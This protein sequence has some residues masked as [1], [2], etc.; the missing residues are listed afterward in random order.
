MSKIKEITAREIKDSRGN[1]TVEVELALSDSRR[2]VASCPSGA[3]VG[4]NE[5]AAIEVSKAIE[6]I[7]EVI[8]PKLR[9]KSLP[10]GR[11]A[12]NQK[13]I[14]EL[15]IALD[16]TENKSHLGVN[17]IL[18]I[19]IA[20][21]RAF[22]ATEKNPL[23][24]Y[25]SQIYNPQSSISNLKL[26]LPCFNFIEGGAHAE[27]DLD[28][29]EFMVIPQK[30]SFRENFVI[31]SQIFQNLKKIL[32]KDFGEAGHGDEGGFAPK[33]NKAEQILLSL[34]SA[35]EK[36]P[37]TK[38][39]LDAA[40]SQFFKEDKYFIEG[41]ELTRTGLLS[42]YKNLVDEFPIIFIE[43]PFNQDDWQ[44]FESIVRQMGEKISIIGDD[45]TTTNIKRIKEA[46]N[47]SACNGIVIKP[48]QIG[49]VTETLEAVKL[50]KSY[51]WRILVAHR[52]GE[53]LDDFIADLA[54]GVGADF[55]K[56]GAP[57]TPERLAKYNRLLEIEETLG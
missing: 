25:I 9:G 19:S 43:D 42:F 27:N 32:E 47:K 40:A 36:Y 22:A 55:I 3:S 44:G 13:E 39:G 17:A 46:Y 18:P 41:Q 48:N 21:C 37:E 14:D 2:V 33:V 49:T 29:Q 23:Y 53:T 12:E 28:F 6:N 38:I 54:V 5:A 8:A 15:M 50:A 1:P 45:L 26:P 30:Q 34:K 4:K 7:N 57:V 56:S 20:V 35:I 10:T 31:A 52:S 24:K 51:G 11:Q 16:G